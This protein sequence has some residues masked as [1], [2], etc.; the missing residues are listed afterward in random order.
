MAGTSAS[1]PWAWHCG[2][3]DAATATTRI[4][5]SSDTR[6]LGVLWWAVL[7][8]KR[9]RRLAVYL[10][11]STQ[12]LWSDEDMAGFIRTCRTESAIWGKEECMSIITFSSDTLSDYCHIMVLL[13]A[14]RGHLSWLIVIK[15]KY[16]RNFKPY[17]AYTY[18][19]GMVG[20]CIK[21][22]GQDSGI[23]TRFS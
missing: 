19:N 8:G 10:A 23:P 9:K 11:L 5:L 6:I 4:M 16:E 1:H 7:E 2:A 15:S 14:R 12:T 18:G 20:R 21:R 3:K 22:W 13:K 17:I